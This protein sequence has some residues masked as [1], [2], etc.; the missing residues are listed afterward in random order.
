MTWPLRAWHLRLK[1]DRFSG[2]RFG[3]Q[4]LVSNAPVADLRRKIFDKLEYANSK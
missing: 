2:L 4:Q 3:I 1:I